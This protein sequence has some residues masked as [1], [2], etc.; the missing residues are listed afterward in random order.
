VKAESSTE[1]VVTTER[2]DIQHQWCW[3]HCGMALLA[4]RQAVEILTDP[5]WFPAAA[6]VGKP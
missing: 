6:V 2:Y 5:F 1:M 3:A 4:R